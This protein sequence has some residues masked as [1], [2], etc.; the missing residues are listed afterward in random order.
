MKNK[1][2]SF[3]ALLFADIA[4]VFLS[5]Y[6]AHL[7]RGEL[8]VV[9]FKKY[10][11]LNMI[12][13]MT[14]LSHSFMVLVW[15]LVFNYEKLYVKRF[16][17]WEEV[18]VLVKGATF[19][20]IFIMI[21]IFLAR[22]E[23][24]FSRTTVV[25]AWLISLFLFPLFRY[26]TKTTLVKMGLWKKKLIMIGVH[27][28]T[29]QVIKNIQKNKT[30]GY[31][32]AAIIDDAPELIG[33]KFAG[34]KVLG[35]LSKIE[36]ISRAYNSKDIMVA[37]P[38]LSRK[39]FKRILSICE[40]NCES[41]WIIPRSGDFITEGV[42]IEVIGDIFT[43]YLKRNLVKPWNLFIK[44]FIDTVL[45]FF[46]LVFTFPFLLVISVAIKLDSKGPI[47]FVQKRIG[48]NNQLFDL[49]KFRSMYM[50]NQARLK[51]YLTS[52][53]RAREE[54]KDFKKLKNHDPR[55]TRVGRFIRKFSL[56]ELPQLF[57]ILNGTMSLVGP[58]PYLPDEIKHNILFLST[59]ARV[60]PGLT[61]LWQI[62]GRSHIPFKERLRIDEYYIR[63]W[64]LWMDVVILLK[65]L[66]A[67]L[68]QKGAF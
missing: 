66:K 3:S 37:T 15:I 45:A 1:L 47:L 43:L 38:H 19:S 2:I 6:L 36:T 8:L 60:K 35:P 20:S 21:S 32:V 58:R 9:L 40:R 27:E 54:W 17:F 22:A 42:N 16:P 31:E 4:V 61:G 53:H 23:H 62:S 29:L 41:M 59:V 49:Y 33:K 26:F 48:K 39:E 55:V 68:S 28:T 46:L 50:D 63:N 7:I 67:T 14:Y 51:A 25:L 34:I 44:S 5:F 65:S 18:K 57:N 64:S 56:D 24:K 12:P 10:Q 30:M 11:S 13:F 52:D